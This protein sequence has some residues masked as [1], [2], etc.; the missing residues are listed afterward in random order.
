MSASQFAEEDK[1]LKAKARAAASAAAPGAGK[2]QQLEDT[3]YRDKRGRKLDMLN[4]MMRQQAIREGKAV[5]E[6]EE[7]ME[8]GKGAVQKEAEKM[9]EEELKNIAAE[10]FARSRNDA[11]V[12]AHYRAQIHADDPMAA[13]M[14]KKRDAARSAGLAASGKPQRP[15]YKGPAPKPNRFGIP[16]GYR[17]D[18]RDRGSAWE[19]KVFGSRAEK[20]R[21]K[22]AAYSYS[23][24]DM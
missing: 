8:W 3:V 22:D 7:Q 9:H 5:A 19:D 12:D 24:S 6:K 15:L 14:T 4:E 2:E 23:V 10:P 18:G 1:A 21:D 11:K 17:W 20:A 13:Y 16:P